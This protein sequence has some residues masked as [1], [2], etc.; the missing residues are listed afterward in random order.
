MFVPERYQLDRSAA[1]Q[2]VARYGRACIVNSGESGLRATYGF[3]LLE[4]SAPVADDDLAAFTVLGHIARGDPQARDLEA[5]TPTLLVFEGPH[6]YV[7]ASWY[8][9]DLTEV[10]STWDYTAVHLFGVPEVLQ[11]EEGLDVVRRTIE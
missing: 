11:G 6:G 7:S 1:Y 3:C 4:N 10:P 5:G 9:P 2:L 8:S